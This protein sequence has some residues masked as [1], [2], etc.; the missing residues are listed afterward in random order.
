MHWWGTGFIPI[1]NYATNNSGGVVEN[2]D[3]FLLD[4][5]PFLLLDLS[6]FLL[7]GP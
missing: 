6:N 5:T 2:E 4:N 3:F 7:L 1:I